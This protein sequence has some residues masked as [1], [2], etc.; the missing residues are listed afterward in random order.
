[1]TQTLQVETDDYQTLISLAAT[2]DL[3]TAG[4]LEQ[5]EDALASGS[6]ARVSMADKIHYNICCACQ[7]PH[8]TE[9]LELVWRAIYDHCGA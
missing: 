2:T 5:F 7:D 8:A 3:L 6:L 1:V 4:T 9:A